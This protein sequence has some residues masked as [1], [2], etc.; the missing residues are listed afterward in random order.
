VIEEP[1]YRPGYVKRASQAIMGARN[2]T[3]ARRRLEFYVKGARNERERRDIADYA[4]MVRMWETMPPQKPP[5][6]PPARPLDQETL[7]E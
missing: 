3:V 2:A 5:Q 6:E 4:E 7:P 1:R